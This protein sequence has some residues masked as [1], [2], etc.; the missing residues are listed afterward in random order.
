MRIW[1][2]YAFGSA[3]RS[4]TNER[5]L[6]WAIARYYRS[7]GYKVTMKPARAGNAMGDGVAV[8]PE[9]ERIAIEVKSPR[10]MSFVESVNAG[11]VGHGRIPQFSHYQDAH[12]VLSLGIEPFN[13]KG[14][15]VVWLDAC[16]YQSTS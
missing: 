15:R 12:T 14:Q 3:K 1:C 5:W 2:P 9:G 4:V 6:K 11:D 8:G 13:R 7:Y 10:T 16:S